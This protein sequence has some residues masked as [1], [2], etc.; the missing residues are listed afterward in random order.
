MTLTH[1]I[2]Y[3]KLFQSMNELKCVWHKHVCNITKL[4]SPVFLKLIIAYTS[5]T[6]HIRGKE[7]T[8]LKLRSH[9]LKVYVKHY[10]IDQALLGIH[11]QKTFMS[12]IINCTLRKN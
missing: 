4:P 10:N 6:N 2:D 9:E 11:S 5:H 7:D 8:N 1:Y 3:I 12:A